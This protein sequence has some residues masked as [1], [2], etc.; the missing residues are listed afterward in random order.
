MP[1]VR[2]VDIEVVRLDGACCAKR[3]ITVRGGTS[4]CA[5]HCMSCAAEECWIQSI[6]FFF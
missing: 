3:K 4:V 6:F 2:G 1:G 5:E